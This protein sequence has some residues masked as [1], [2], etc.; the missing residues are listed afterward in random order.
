MSESIGRITSYGD[1]VPIIGHLSIISSHI[2]GCRPSFLHAHHCPPS[3]ASILRWTTKK[4]SN[5]TSFRSS[6][7]RPTMPCCYTHWP[8][9]RPRRIG[10]TTTPKKLPGQ[11]ASVRSWIARGC[12][13]GPRKQHRPSRID[14]NKYV[15]S[16]FQT[17]YATDKRTPSS[18]KSMTS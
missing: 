9:R 18:S 17:T 3:V 11:H 13:G 1:L 16:S 6:G 14:G 4:T 12:W 7:P 5:Q 2:S 8:T 15:L 10:A